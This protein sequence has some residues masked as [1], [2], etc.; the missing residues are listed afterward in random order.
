MVHESPKINGKSKV[1]VVGLLYKIGRPDPVLAK[2]TSL[3]F[4]DP[5]HRNIFF[6]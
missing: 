2:V 4:V 3:M 1:A 5:N 6:W